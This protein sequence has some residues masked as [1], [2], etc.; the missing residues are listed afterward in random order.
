MDYNMR[1]SADLYRAYVKKFDISMRQIHHAGESCSMITLA[2]QLR[3]SINP[4]VKG[5]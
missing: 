3:S 1:I 4:P 5:L 2:K